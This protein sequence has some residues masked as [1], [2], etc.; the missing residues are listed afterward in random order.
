MLN[1]SRLRL[2]ISSGNVP[3]KI[4]Q[5]INS[6]SFKLKVILIVMEMTQSLLKY[7]KA[8]AHAADQQ[9]VHNFID[10]PIMKGVALSERMVSSYEVYICPLICKTTIDD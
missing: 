7:L 1:L 9:Y 8:C 6:I 2:P 5:A 4:H 10:S 3:A